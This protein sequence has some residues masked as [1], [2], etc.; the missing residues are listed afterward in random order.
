MVDRLV[1]MG[2]RVGERRPY[3]ST[4]QRY[5]QPGKGRAFIPPQ[6]GRI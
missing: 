3:L 1:P 5:R 6:L 2:P 4:S